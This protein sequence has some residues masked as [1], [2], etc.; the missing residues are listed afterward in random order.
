MKYNFREFNRAVAYYKNQLKKTEF[1]NAFIYGIFNGQAFLSLAP[2]S[3]AIH[4]SGKDI[5]VSFSDREENIALFDIWREYE[6]GNNTMNEFIDLIDKKTKRKFK[7]L[8]KK[9][10]LILESQNNKFK[11]TIEL[12]Y[13]S[14]WFMEYLPDRLDQT[15]KIILKEVINPKKS[16]KVAVSFQLIPSQKILDEPLE[17]YL[18]SYAISLSVINNSLNK[19]NLLKISSSTNRESM[20]D[21]PEIISELITTLLGCELSKNIDEPVFKIYKK[22]SKELNLSR[23]KPSNAVFGIRGKGYHGRHYFGESIGYPTP[24]KKSRWDSPAGIL[25]KFSW[26]PQSHLDSRKPQ[27]RIGFTSTVPIDIFIDSVLVDYKKM[28]ARNKKIIDIMNKCEK[29]IVKSDI[30]KGSDFEV[31]LIKKDMTR[32]EVKPSDSDA[33]YL[34]NPYYKKQGK[35]FGMMANIPGGEAFTTPEYVKGKIAGDVVISLDRSYRLSPKNPLLIEVKNNKYKIISGEKKIIEQLNKKRKEAWQR[36]LEQKK[37]KSIPCELIELKKKNFDNIGEFAINTNPKA[38][39]CDYLIVNEKIANMI[40]IALG[41]GFE[42]DKAT[43]YHIDIVIDSPRQKLDIYGLD[44]N[45]NTNWIIKKGRFV[46]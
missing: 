6:Q 10:E 4:D 15:G 34:Y 14:D 13:N 46:I 24:D 31:G 43:E 7:E 40:H 41:S 42:A 12:D 17:D 21:D 23:I 29:I 18:D 5:Y 27:S 39:L 11:G 35:Y 22:L 33:R 20:L 32:R 38:R 19:Y 37:N 16:E 36:I 44:K 45:S 8:F 28:R 9:P 25:Y 30:E 2:L 3:R 1:Q 26:Y